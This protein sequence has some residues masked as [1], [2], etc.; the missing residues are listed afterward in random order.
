MC[1]ITSRR[2][3]SKH[4]TD[5]SRGRRAIRR[6][7]EESA[8]RMR[9]RKAI[10]AGRYRSRSKE[11]ERVGAVF[12]SAEER[13]QARGRFF[14]GNFLLFLLLFLFLLFFLFGCGS[15]CRSG[16]RR[17]DGGF[18]GLVDVHAFQRGGQGLH[19]GLID[20]HSGGGEDLLQVLFANRLTG[21]MEDQRPVHIFHSLSPPSRSSPEQ[22]PE[23]LVGRVWHA[24]R[25][26]E[27]LGVCLR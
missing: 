12:G 20:L 3:R 16:S 25:Q 21:R 5:S 26:G 24:G 19:A 9:R 1:L 17:G 22:R 15:G 6:N 13:T 4:T 27:H 10:E 11:M 8:P 18:E 2:T 23:L 7:S 14:L